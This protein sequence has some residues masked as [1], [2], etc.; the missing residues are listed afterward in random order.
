MRYLPGALLLLS[1]P[2][3]AEMVTFRV[4]VPRCTPPGDSVLL[5]SN[6]LEPG[7]FLHEPMRPVACDRWEL[8][9]EVVTAPERFEYKY[10][11]SVCDAIRCPGIEK[12]LT[13]GGA[14]DEIAPRRLGTGQLET[15]D[16]VFVWR[17]MWRTFDADGQPIGYRTTRELS[18][19]CGPYLGMLTADGGLG[20]GHDTFAPAEVVLEWGPDASYG[21]RTSLA[22]SQRHI[23][24][25][26]GLPENDPVHYR[27]TVDGVPGPDRTFLAP[28]GPEGTLRFVHLGDAQYQE[29]ATRPRVRALAARALAFQPHLILGT[30][31]MVASSPDGAGGFLAPEV[32]RWSVFF[33]DVAE[34]L[35]A[36]PH[37]TAMGN[38][39][40]DGPY[41]W[42]AFLR[43]LTDP[44]KLDHFDFRLGHTH[45]FVLY[46]GKTE[47]YDLEGILDSQTPWLQAR[48]EAAA[49]DPR[50]RW[51]VV[52][53]HRGPFSQGGYHAGEGLRFSDG[54]TAARPAWRALWE[55]HGVDLV[56]AGHNHN[57]T[58]AEVNGIR[59]V[60]ECGG[61]HTHALD[62]PWAPSTVYAE[63]TCSLGEFTA[64]PRTLRF[65]AFRPDGS[66]IAAA[67]LALCRE[68][69]D[70]QELA[71]PC[72]APASAA[73]ACEDRACQARC[74][75]LEDGGPD[76][77]E[78]EGQ[79][80]DGSED[81]GQGEGPNQDGFE[82]E[83]QEQDGLE[84]G[85]GG[86]CGC[87]PTDP[88]AGLAT[89]PLLGLLGLGALV[90]S[91]SASF[92][93]YP[94]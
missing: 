71:D 88:D 82:G 39:E 22:G 73:W 74:G 89:L 24:A 56:L 18:A 17:D 63:E 21:Q 3:L 60:T 16:Q 49:A 46:T 62:Q 30:G 9:V 15:D 55:Q 10:T 27:V 58:L 8:E 53:L 19:F 79:E 20:L 77:A 34:L 87:G 36:A 28:P 44:P 86:G 40:E 91:R 72:P 13:Y 80:G 5:R 2:A 12:D 59:Y 94:R 25:F 64:S 67:R 47:G 65:Q 61:A 31:D 66:E 50:V 41:F 23:L 45:F 37:A 51:K 4:E 7:E 81:G 93:S 90:R 92:R 33:G 48:L 57:F 11:H 6:R 68:D 35:A 42:D 76:G 54:G 84:G 29:P 14:G 43:P 78:E 85:G 38:H 70:C 75:V 83:G 1:A 26:E 32:G 69:A 52:A